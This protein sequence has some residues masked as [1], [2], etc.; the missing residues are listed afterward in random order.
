MPLSLQQFSRFQTRATPQ[1]DEP[2]VATP[3]AS[4][5][6]VRLASMGFRPIPIPTSPLEY[7]MVPTSRKRQA[8]KRN[9]QI[10]VATGIAVLL[11]IAALVQYTMFFS[12][13][14]QNSVSRAS[15][16]TVK[17]QAVVVSPEIT[18]FDK[19]PES[20][21]EKSEPAR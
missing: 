19:A 18:A 17:P 16:V 1:G 14:G 5:K 3:R 9:I 11:A 15:Q 20:P 10:R 12:E 8:R 21:V 2:A 4:T 6:G 13:D 7:P